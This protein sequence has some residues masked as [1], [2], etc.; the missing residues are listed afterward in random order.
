M[1]T[2]LEILENAIRS[3]LLLEIATDGGLDNQRGTFG[4]VLAQGKEDLW[5]MAGPVDGDPHTSNSKRSELA[6]YVASLEMLL[7]LV[8]FLDPLPTHK[9][10]TTT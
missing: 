1:T 10:H 8:T 3:G 7:M 4:V 5:E 9:I 6:G 2:A